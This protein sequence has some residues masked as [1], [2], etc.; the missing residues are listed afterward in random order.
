MS[1]RAD[2]DLTHAARS[3]AASVC[4]R[5]QLT[6]LH[7]REK[8]TKRQKQIVLIG[9][10]SAL[11]TI[12]DNTR[13][14]QREAGDRHQLRHQTR[15]FNGFKTPSV[16]LACLLTRLFNVFAIRTNYNGIVKGC[17]PDTVAYLKINYS[18]GTRPR[19]AKRQMLRVYTCR[20]VTRVHNDCA[21]RYLYARID[22]PHQTM[23]ADSLSNT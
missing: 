18:R 15:T 13:T 12:S 21:V 2:P 7:H 10:H 22:L 17:S 16:K 4:H 23:G 19:G 20:I 11:S 6:A 3:R 9:R 8:E 5:A 1:S 14:K